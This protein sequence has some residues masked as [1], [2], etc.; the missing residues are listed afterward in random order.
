[1][2]ATIAA[3]QENGQHQI[4]LRKCAQI[5]WRGLT[6]Q[7]AVIGCFGDV[8]L[9]KAY[10]VMEI[11]YIYYSN[12]M[13]ILEKINYVRPEFRKSDYAGRLLD[14]AKQASDETGLDLMIGIVSD[15]RLEAKERFYARKLKKAGVWFI[16]HPKNQ[17]A[18]E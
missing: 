16:H 4:D 5:I 3:H 18:A 11:D 9:V 8:S 15:K 10:I 13:Q 17:I 14:F 12:E 7:M 2:D 6:K 1:M